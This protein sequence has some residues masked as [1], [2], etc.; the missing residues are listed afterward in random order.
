MKSENVLNKNNIQDILPLAPVQKGMLFYYLNE[1]DSAMYF[2]QMSF[3]VS[4]SFNEQDF[5]KAWNVIVQ[6]H[7]ILRTLFRWKKLDNPVQ[8]VLK[9]YEIPLIIHDLTSIP[10][11]LQQEQLEKIW[12]QDRKEGINIEIAPMRILLIRLTPEC[13]EMTLSSYHIILDGWSNGIILSDFL[14]AY[15]NLRLGKTPQNTACNQGYGAFIK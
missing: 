9:Q 12:E 2:E 5:R 4:G 8:I 13:F 3:R 10:D 14:D 7:P 1:K 15:L 6:K 11:D